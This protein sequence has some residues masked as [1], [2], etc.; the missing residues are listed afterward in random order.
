MK[1]LPP[2]D[3]DLGFSEFLGERIEKKPEEIKTD[4]SLKELF[5]AGEYREL[6]KLAEK[7]FDSSSESVLWWIRAQIKLNEV[8]LSILSAP[9]ERVEKDPN[10]ELDW[11]I[12]ITAEELKLLSEPPPA[13]PVEEEV[14]LEP[15]NKK[16]KYS[17]IWILIGLLLPIGYYLYPSR[18]GNWS[19]DLQLPL[20]VFLPSEQQRITVDPLDLVLSQIE[21]V[22]TL[23]QTLAEASL[24]P[25][26]TINMKGPTLPTREPVISGQREVLVDTVV[27]DR[28]SIKGDIIARLAQGAL[29]EVLGEAG[30]F[31]RIRSKLGSDGFVIKQD[32]G[33]ILPRKTPD[34]S[35]VSPFS[36]DAFG[37]RKNY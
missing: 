32:I 18:K 27:L 6:S 37:D 28:P 11:L 14:K 34:S 12:K 13:T 3:L 35:P 16:K 10:P 19:S 30:P 7:N 8:P 5:E 36:R 31:Y 1:K 9:F 17:W 33:S 15:N 21:A 29:V 23:A 22:P 2:E 24:A 26:P 20:P 4:P 25:K